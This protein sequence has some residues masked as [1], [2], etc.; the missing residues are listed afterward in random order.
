MK[1]EDKKI[2]TGVMNLHRTFNVPREQVWKAWSD[3]ETFSKWFGPKDYTT[4]F[5]SIDF[6]MGGKILNCMQGPDGKKIWSTGS[7][8]EI[9]PYEKIVC[10]DHFADE[11]GNI[12]PAS[13]YGLSEEFPEEMLLSLTFEDLGEKTRLSL[14]HSGMSN[15]SEEDLNEM[16]RGWNQSLDKLADLLKEK[17]DNEDGP[18]LY[19]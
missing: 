2:K 7:Y 8:R 3:P 15:I 10:S 13:Y 18:T 12:V 4:P 11:K 5:A 6:K 1:K 17:I 16:E 14:N 19:Y 9:I